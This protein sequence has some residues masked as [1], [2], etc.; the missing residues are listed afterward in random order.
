MAEAVI[1]VGLQGAGK[2]TYYRKTLA[3]THVLVSGDIQGTP[4][5]QDEVLHECIR[6][7]QSFAIDNTNITREVRAPYIR[8]AKAAGYRIL[9]CYLDTPMRVALGRNHHRDDKKAIPA[10]A[11]LRAAKQ[12]QPPGVDEGFDEISIIRPS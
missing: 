6:D 3:D 7:G 2:T 10:P 8:M 1:L 12:L 11:I 5:R 4:R 9:C